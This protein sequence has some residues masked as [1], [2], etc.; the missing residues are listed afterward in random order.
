MSSVLSFWWYVDSKSLSC[1]VAE[2]LSLKYFGVTTLTLLGHGTTSITWPSELQLVVSYWSSIDTMSLYLAPLPRYW[3]SII[4]GSRLWPL[5][6]T[7]RHAMVTSPLGFGTTHGPFLL[8]VCWHQVTI[9]HSCR[10]IEPQTFWGHD[11]DPFGSRNV[12]SHVTI[13]TTVG[14][15]LLGIRWHHVPISHHCRDIKRQ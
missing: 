7:W 8:V 6:V 2:I 4:T 10:D 3:A 14:C 15:F 9:L 5:G 1:T 12:I 11:L 13:G